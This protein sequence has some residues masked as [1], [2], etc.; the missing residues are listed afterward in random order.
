MCKKKTE[1]QS[2][3]NDSHCLS[4]TEAQDE[5]IKILSADKNLNVIMI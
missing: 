2:I 1:Q 5:N 4:N 3:A